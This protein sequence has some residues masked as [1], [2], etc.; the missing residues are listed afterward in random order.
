[1]TL[2]NNADTYNA[3]TTLLSGTLS[4]G[5]PS[6]L[7]SGA[8]NLLGG[9]VQAGIATSVS[10]AVNL[11]SVGG[12]NGTVTL[13]GNTPLTFSGQVNVAGGNTLTLANS[14]GTTISGKLAGT[15]SLSLVSGAANGT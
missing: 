5:N 15:G 4:I 9:T 12:P 8:L 3:G 6:G 11:S 13:G 2:L 7:G 1:T 10:N 14:A